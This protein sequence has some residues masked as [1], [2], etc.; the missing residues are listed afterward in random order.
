MKDSREKI[1]QERFDEEMAGY[2]NDAPSLAE[3]AGEFFQVLDPKEKIVVFHFKENPETTLEAIQA[4]GLL[5][6]LGISELRGILR[7]KRVKDA[8]GYLGMLDKEVSEDDIRRRLTRILM[9]PMSSETAAL[10]ASVELSKI[11]SIYAKKDEVE[12]ERLSL[13]NLLSHAADVDRKEYRKKRKKPLT[14]ED[15]LNTETDGV[16]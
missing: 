5:P 1:E 3:Q 14:A 7:S 10:R 12:R 15:T 11:M 13:R 2:L 4:S 8:L 9:S 16:D 6:K